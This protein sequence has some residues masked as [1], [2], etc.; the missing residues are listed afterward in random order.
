MVVAHICPS[1]FQD[2]S[3][4]NMTLENLNPAVASFY[5]L[6]STMSSAFFLPHHSV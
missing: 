3:Q 5:A 2:P 4:N 1:Y 6:P